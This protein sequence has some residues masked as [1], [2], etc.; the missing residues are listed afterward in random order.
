MDLINLFH[1]KSNL[2]LYDF[3]VPNDQL[4]AIGGNVV[5]NLEHGFI[6]KDAVIFMNNHPAHTKIDLVKFI[7]SMKDSPLFF[8]GWNQFTS[9]E[10]ERINSCF[11]STMGYLSS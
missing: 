10:V 3:V 11:Y 2:Y 6:G 8:D 7:G 1:E 5:N 9:T 4:E